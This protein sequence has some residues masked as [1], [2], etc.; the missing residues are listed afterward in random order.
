MD[1]AILIPKVSLKEHLVDRVADFIT[2][3]G[4]RIY[5]KSKVGRI[6]TKDD[7][8]V[9][10]ELRNRKH[11]RAISYISAV[12]HQSL[13]RILPKSLQQ[14]RPFDAFPRF[15][16]SPIVSIHL[17]FD[18]PFTDRPFVGLIDKRVQWV[19]NRR[20]IAGTREGSLS[21]FTATVSGAHEIVDLTRE[22]LIW[23]ALQDLEAVFPESKR[24]RLLHA[25]VMKEKEAT[26]SIT[27]E[28][29]NL[30]PSIETP[31][32]NL[33]LAGDWVDTGLPATIESAVKSGFHA[34]DAA[35]RYRGHQ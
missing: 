7:R 1:S 20:K 8:V 14:Q 33:F 15:D 23:L 27:P 32:R 24:A 16:S 35:L 19:F 4:G 12:P 18:R 3:Q 10:I 11:F 22:D 5:L 28:V 9:G 25:H 30:R 34:A 13:F 17:W 21:Y 2:E 26:I 6:L 31:L 29:E